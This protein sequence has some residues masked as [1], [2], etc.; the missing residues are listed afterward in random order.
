MSYVW[1]LIACI[2]LWTWGRCVTGLMSCAMF[3]QFQ[4]DFIIFVW[5]SIQRSQRNFLDEFSFSFKISWCRDVVMSWCH[6]AAISW[7]SDV[8]TPWC[9]DVVMPWCRD[10]IVLWCHNAVM[11]WC[12]DVII[13]LNMMDSIKSNDIEVCNN[14]SSRNCWQL[15]S[16]SIFQTVDPITILQPVRTDNVTALNIFPGAT[17]VSTLMLRFSKERLNLGPDLSPVSRFI[18]HLH[19]HEFISLTIP[20]ELKYSEN[21]CDPAPSYIPKR[22]PNRDRY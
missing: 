5:N 10:V 7:C 20:S 12:R 11:S 19:G 22:S 14:N 16:F 13:P 3:V 4:T 21:I 1:Q 6:N 18:A 2:M 17:G 15:I 9:H 8:I